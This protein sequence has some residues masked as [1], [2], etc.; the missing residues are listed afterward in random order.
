MA[1]TST[2]LRESDLK[3]EAPEI[4]ADAVELITCIKAITRVQ[5]SSFV[6]LHQGL[7]TFQVG[8]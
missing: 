2:V 6:Q 1:D 7:D 8:P 5:G 3:V 4:D